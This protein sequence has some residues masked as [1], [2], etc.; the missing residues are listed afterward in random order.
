MKKR[1]P[2]EKRRTT[3]NRLDVLEAAIRHIR[4]VPDDHEARIATLETVW[5]ARQWVNTKLATEPGDV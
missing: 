4:A 3:A 5:K 2:D 1:K